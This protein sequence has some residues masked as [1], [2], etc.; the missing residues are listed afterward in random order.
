MKERNLQDQL[1]EIYK[2]EKPKRDV[3]GRRPATREDL[4]ITTP[5]PKQI[6]DAIRP[7][8]KIMNPSESASE[9]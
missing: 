9:R 7:S 2:K 6:Q 1:K 5:T 4:G 8:K 3:F